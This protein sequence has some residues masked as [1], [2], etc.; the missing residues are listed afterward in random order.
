M[1]RQRGF[2]LVKLLAVMAILAVLSAIL[3]PRICQNTSSYDPGFSFASANP[4]P[5]Y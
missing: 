5:D 1:E 4:G 3:F 2:T